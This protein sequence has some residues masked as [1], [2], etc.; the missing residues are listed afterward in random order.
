[1]LKF[2]LVVEQNIN[3]RGVTVISHSD[4]RLGKNGTGV[5]VEVGEDLS[6]WLL[7]SNAAFDFAPPV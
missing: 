5:A 6:I 4:C 1:V 2:I 7:Q 3:T